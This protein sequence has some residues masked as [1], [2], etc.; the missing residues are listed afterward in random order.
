MYLLTEWKGQT[1]KYL[2]ALGPYAMTEC[3][4]FPVWPD[5]MKARTGPYGSYNNNDNCFFG[6]R[7]LLVG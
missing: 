2:A 5:A 6:S 1:G 4:I 3:Q 7:K